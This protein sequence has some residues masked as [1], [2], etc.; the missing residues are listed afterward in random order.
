MDRARVE[1]RNDLTYNFE[2]NRGLQQ[3][4]GLA[5]LLFNTALEYALRQLS[6]QIVG[7]ADDMNVMER[8]MQTEKRCI[9]I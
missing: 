8:P 9:E 6:G 1:I 2:V 3:G 7:Y 4:D 5:P